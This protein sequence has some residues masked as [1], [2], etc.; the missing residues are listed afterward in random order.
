[1]LIK[2]IKA[3]AIIEANYIFAIEALEEYEDNNQKDQIYQKFSFIIEKQ[4][5]NLLILNLNIIHDKQSA[6]I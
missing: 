6:K 1:M 2:F 4:A 3:P 5:Q